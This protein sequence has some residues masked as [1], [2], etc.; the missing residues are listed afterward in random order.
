MADLPNPFVL[1][2]DHRFTLDEAAFLAAIEPAPAFLEAPRPEFLQ[3]VEILPIVELIG[4][5]LQP[6]TRRAV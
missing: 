6:P 3:A 5:F 2:P 1:E 4:S